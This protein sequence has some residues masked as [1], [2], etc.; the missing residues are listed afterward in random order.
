M[1]GVGKSPMIS[2]METISQVGDRERRHS[3]NRLV[4]KGEHDKFVTC[5]PQIDA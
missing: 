2:G 3:G 5:Y 4:Y 1:N